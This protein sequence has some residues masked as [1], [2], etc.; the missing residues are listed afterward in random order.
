MCCIDGLVPLSTSA[1]HREPDLALMA[2]HGPC[3]TILSHTALTHL[4]H[5][6]LKPLY[7]LHNPTFEFAE[8]RCVCMHVH[9]VPLLVVGK[10]AL[11]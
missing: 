10:F 3:K 8:G 4:T 5:G 2:T 6:I 1:P 7:F 9:L 11:N